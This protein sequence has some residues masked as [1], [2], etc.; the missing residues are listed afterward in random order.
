MSRELAKPIIFFVALGLAAMMMLSPKSLTSPIFLVVGLAGVGLI[1]FLFAIS[2]SGVPN[3]E[4]HGSAKW[5]STEDLVKKDLLVDNS[6]APIEGSLILGPAPNNPTKRLDLPL[7]LMLRHLLILG[8]TGSGKG[9][10][11]FLWQLPNFNGSF[12]YCDP[13]GEGWRLASGYRKHSWRFAPRQPDNSSCFNWIPLCGN[14]SHLCLTLAQAI[15]MSSGGSSSADSQFW[16]DAGSQYLAALFAHT[17][18]FTTPTPA[19]AY[20][21]AT[22][23]KGEVLLEQLLESTNPIS[24]QYATLFSAADPKL[25]GNVMIGANAK[26]IWLADEKVRRF[27]SASLEPPDFGSLRNKKIGVYWVLSEK[28]VTLL[29]P[30]STLFFTLILYQ[31]KEA[32]G[33]VPICLLLDELANIGRIPKL[34]VEIT[35]LRGRGI[36]L[37]LGVQ[38]LEQLD[39]VY[40]KDAAKVI[41]GNCISKVVLGGLVDYYTIKYVSDLLGSQTISEVATSRSKQ[42]GL[43]G[44]VTTSEQIVK[45]A[46]PL[47]TPDEVRRIPKGQQLVII[48]NNLP[49]IGGRYIY[50]QA[51]KTASASVLGQALTQVFPKIEP[52]TKTY[53]PDKRKANPNKQFVRS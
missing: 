33:T 6:L 42:A 15:I 11:F 35:I 47:M 32:E 23:Y 12:V 4:L 21:F 48:D 37:V 45:T 40:G 52:E 24:R 44:K 25:R 38:S 19:A 2:R 18:T 26:L 3:S 51:D 27:T 53:Y 10:G 5:A 46:R 36:G 7:D 31:L 17:S 30:L 14:D 22:T 20:D 1:L 13:K 9:R 49:I 43:F 29:Q 34:E 16:I 41:A 8:S 50:T 28:D 39:N